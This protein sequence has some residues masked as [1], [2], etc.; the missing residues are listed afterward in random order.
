MN[1]QTPEP[2]ADRTSVIDRLKAH[3]AAHDGQEAMTLP[4]TGIVATFPAFRPHGLIMRAAKVAG[5][6]AQKMQV[7]YIAQNVR[8]DGEKLTLSDIEDLV[9]DDD[10]AALIKRLFVGSDDEDAAGND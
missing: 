8:F 4:K 10:S 7:V 9:P 3:K 5:N 2:I 6:D 1:D